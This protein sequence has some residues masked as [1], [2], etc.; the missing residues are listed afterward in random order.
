MDHNGFNLVDAA[1]REMLERGFLPDFPLE[2]EQQLETIRVEPERS[3]RD[4]TSLLWSSI[5]NDDSRD[6]DQIEWAERTANGIR[7]LVGIA[8]VD[9]AVAKGTPIDAHAAH[10]TTT[11]YAGVRNFPMLPERLSTDLTSLS[12]TGDRAAVV[13]EMLV[14]PDGSLTDGQ[15]YRAVTRNHAQL[16]YST[17][18][19]WL[20]G[21]APPPSKVAASADLK[22]QLELQNEAAHALRAARGRLGA[23]SFDRV[24]TQ[25]VVSNGH[26]RD[27]TARRQNRAS[28]LIEDFMIGANEVMARTLREARVSSIRRVVKAP[29]RWPRIMELA[30]HYGEKL[31]SEPDSGALNAFLVRRKQADPV[32]YPDVSLSILKLMG[33]G[34]YVLSRQGDS[35]QGHFGLAAQDYTH[36]TAPNRR[37]ADLVTQR[38]LKAL[39]GPAPYTDDELAA[40]ARNCTLKEDAAR[41]VQRDMNKRICAVGLLPRVG[42]TFPAVVTGV[43]HKGVFVRVLD[44]PVE[45]RLIHGEEGLD[46][47]DRLQVRLLGADPQRGFIDFGRN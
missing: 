25:A 3:L 18:G 14:S 45:G 26:V 31:P 23:L 10:E 46:V 6:L 12:E 9:S 17:V 42:Q 37:F 38:L 8:D 28:R 47:G 4:M 30:E 44:P 29:E 21:S 39:G 34:E 35:E 32:H 16:T 27:V 43:T 15:I 5:D 33:P 11:V 24:E 13:I 41:K 22:A 36:S 7:V 20:E 2:V 19:P 1:R 40:I